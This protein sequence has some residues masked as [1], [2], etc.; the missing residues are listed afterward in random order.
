[1][2]NDAFVIHH[3]TNT[4][5]D[6]ERTKTLPKPVF[7]DECLTV[8]H[9]W[10]D[11]AY[12]L[13]IDPGMHDYWETGVL[14]IRR[15]IMNYENQ[16]GTMIWAWVDD[17]FAVPGRGIGCWRRDLPAIRYTELVYKL[18]GRGYQGDCV[19][20]VVDGWRRPRP[21][22][23]LMKKVYTPVL[24]DE[25]PLTLPAS[26]SP[27]AVPLEN[28]NWFANLNAYECRWEIGGQKGTV[29]ADVPA[30]SKGVLNIPAPTAVTDSETLKLEWYDETG[31]MVDAYK[32]RF[33][34][35]A[36]P[37]WQLGK[38]ASI[39]EENGRYLSGAAGVYL[40]GNQCEIAYD[41]VSGG[42]MWGLKDNEQVL[43]SGPTLHIL[44]GE[45]PTADDP[46]GWKFTGESHEAGLI[47]WNGVFGNEYEGGYTIRMDEAG[48]IEIAYEF[49]YKGPDICAREVG[50]QWELPRAF[51]RLS[52]D[53]A[54]EHSVYPDD[55]IGRP[56]GTALAHSPAAQTVPPNGRPFGLDDHPWGSN[57]FRS[58]KRDIYWASLSNK[59]GQGVKVI[60]DG[61]QSVRC[62][63][64]VHGVSLKVLDYYG[65]TGGK[66]EWS[67]LGFHYGP[68]K[69]IKT[70]DVLKGTVRL[71]LVGDKG[72]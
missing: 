13:E 9:G 1:M 53:R 24:I 45:R 30:S 43:S 27:I 41:K 20:G 51:D 58:A 68:G 62:T 47:H 15:Q 46:Q 61:T 11:F 14:G 6:I 5:E 59:L 26:G 36:K 37:Q 23:W 67:V 25:K 18:P 28:M 39:A 69:L 12:S 66:N 52:W 72:N 49:K 19:W 57:D 48:Q 34:E 8:Y 50:L 29:R 40:K 32:L 16:M 22:W 10:G 31:R 42:M 21:E 33:K 64:G 4:H 70:G 65:G 2:D 35:H 54:A 3:P 56:T 55:H 7:Y 60:S 63:L 17:A 44:N 71:Q 38:A